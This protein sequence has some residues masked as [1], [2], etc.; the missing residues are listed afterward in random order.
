MDDADGYFGEPVA[1]AYD[2]ESAE[3][4]APA[5]VDPVVDL[6]A[7]SRSPARASSTCRSGRRRRASRT[8]LPGSYDGR[9]RVRR[10]PVRRRS[11]TCWAGANADEG[12]SHR[13]ERGLLG[14]RPRGGGRAGSLVADRLAAGRCV[15]GAG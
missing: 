8:L 14:D 10:R 3:M 12:S 5:A 7:G 6:L 11:M 4:F 1:A 13:G 9:V 15:A 2:E